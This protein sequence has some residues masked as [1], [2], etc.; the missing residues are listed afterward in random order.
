MSSSRST[1]IWFAAAAL[2]A[3]PREPVVAPAAGAPLMA[4][5]GVGVVTALGLEVAAGAWA[6][7]E[8]A[9]GPG[10]RP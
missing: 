2:V 7:S 5:G 6:G 3:L 8:P 1:V 4:A 10:R 9:T